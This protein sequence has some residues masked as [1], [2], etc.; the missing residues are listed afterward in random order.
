MRLPQELLKIRKII[1]VSITP[2]RYPL[3]HI[4]FAGEIVDAGSDEGSN[5]AVTESSN[6]ENI[7]NK[8][9]P[10]LQ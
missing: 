1:S 4:D 3:N 8:L 10:N 5:N 2:L 9:K 6:F 7:F